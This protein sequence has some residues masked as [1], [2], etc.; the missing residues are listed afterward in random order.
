MRRWADLAGVAGE[1]RFCA[2][3]RRSPQFGSAAIVA[4]RAT[5]AFGSKNDLQIRAKLRRNCRAILSVGDSS[6]SRLSPNS[7]VHVLPSERRS[8]THSGHQDRS[9]GGSTLQ[10]LVNLSAS[11]LIPM[12]YQQGAGGFVFRRHPGSREFRRGSC[13]DAS[14]MTFGSR[15][16][17]RRR[18]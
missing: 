11:M 3:S 10:C 6:Y 12:S 16:Q 4:D 9:A 2:K 17:C 13:R 1:L 14:A 5:S 8:L 7:G 15:R 18:R